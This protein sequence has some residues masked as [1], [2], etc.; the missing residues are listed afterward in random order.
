M[1][2]WGEMNNFLDGFE[3]SDI[4]TSI[5]KSVVFENMRWNSNLRSV[6]EEIDYARDW[7]RKRRFFL[8]ERVPFI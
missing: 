2:F 3:A 6:S 7:F 5:N 8:D 4:A 1:S